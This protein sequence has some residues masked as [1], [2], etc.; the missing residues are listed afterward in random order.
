MVSYSSRRAQVSNLKTYSMFYLP[1]LFH[2]LENQ[3]K[4]T[5]DPLSDDQERPE[6]ETT[7]SL[8]ITRLLHLLVRVRPMAALV[9]LPTFES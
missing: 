6:R 5:T 4:N 8:P 2:F 9:L 7:L 3:A 1:S